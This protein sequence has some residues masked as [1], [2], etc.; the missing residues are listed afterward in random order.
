ME[1]TESITALY[2]HVPFCVRKCNYCNFNSIEHEN[3]IVD[4][5]VNAIKKE[6]DLIRDKYVFRTIYI[7]G[8]TPTVLNENQLRKLLNLIKG[9][10][11]YSELIEYTVEANP[12][13]LNE[14]KIHIL[15]NNHVNRVSLGAQ[16][17]N[18]THLKTLGRIHTYKNTYHTYSLLRKN[19]FSNINIDL[20]FGIPHQKVKEW[21]DDLNLVISLNPEHISTY[22]LTYENGT[23][24]EKLIASGD[25]QK[26]DESDEIDM[27]K[28][29]I[30]LLAKNGFN[31][32][33]ISNFAK[34]GND[35]LHNMVYWKNQEYI[36]I[37]PGACS[38]ING[39]RTSNEK[40]VVK[41]I[42]NV[43]TH[44][45]N[46]T[47]FEH[48]PPREHAAETVI[49]GLRMRSGISN[50][51][52]F[53]QTGFQFTDI[54][55]AQISELKNTGHI[56]YNNNRLSLTKKGLFVAD[57]VMMEFLN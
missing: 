14:E 34:K 43:D 13:T 19:G 17:F 50:N 8:G 23:V 48:L 38:F 49:M 42:Q 35:S 25:Y 7:G 4:A 3:S 36:G 22:S 27:Y 44:K 20:I 52:F 30:S 9:C 37:G 11:D 56:N 45:G 16:S 12:G 26:I 21:L 15:K 53:R 47:F 5:Y 31:H 32:Y 6:L 40:D 55:G 39:K 57:S 54:F 24:F 2:I 18:D 41:Y 51:R 1:N 46:T 33:E 10:I 28:S 29:A